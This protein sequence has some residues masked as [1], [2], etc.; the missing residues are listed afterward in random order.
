[1]NSGIKL[2]DQ[3]NALLMDEDLT[4]EKLREASEGLLPNLVDYL[5]GCGH[6]ADGIA[7]IL[8]ERREQITKH[9]RTINNDIQFNEDEQLR[10]AARVL[11]DPVPKFENRPF[12]WDRAIW[13]KMINKPYKER[14][15]ISGAL[16]AAE[17]DRLNN[18]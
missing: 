8:K 18:M 7:L 1:M 4:D 15:I 5:N 6:N 2:I 17:I 10:V 12:G 11:L 3:L 16:I 13:F 14:L 9:F